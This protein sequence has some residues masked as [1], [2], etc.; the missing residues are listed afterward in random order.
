[1][2]IHHPKVKEKL[3][4]SLPFFQKSIFL[5]H[6]SLNEQNNK[7]I[8]NEMVLVKNT[9]ISERDRETINNKQQAENNRLFKT[10]KRITPKKLKFKT[11]MKV[12]NKK[13]NLSQLKKMSEKIKGSNIPIVKCSECGSSIRSNNL[14]RH[15][16]KTLLFP[17]QT[18][19]SMC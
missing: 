2:D 3:I 17:V 1:M 7:Y 6:L 13:R 8:R 10:R 16:I 18:I 12:L 5:K 9:D 14:K 11:K 19:C 4:I 15:V